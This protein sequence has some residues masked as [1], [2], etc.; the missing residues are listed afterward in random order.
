MAT[1]LL[2]L[3]SAAVLS[4][5]FRRRSLDR[6]ACNQGAIYF[7]YLRAKHRHLKSRSFLRK[8]FFKQG[9]DW[10]HE[11]CE[12]KHLA[13]GVGAVI[14]EFSN[15]DN[16][17]ISEVNQQSLFYYLE[18]PNLSDDKNLLCVT[19]ER[20]SPSNDS[21]FAPVRSRITW[22]PFLFNL[23]QFLPRNLFPANSS[24]F[25]LF[26]AE[27]QQKRLVL[28]RFYRQRERFI[29]EGESLRIYIHLFTLAGYKN[30]IKMI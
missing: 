13:A 3:I 14:K 4:S 9:L 29:M 16:E 23:S 12:T 2:T 1:V 25:T 15:W 30:Y 28:C 6:A 18:S 24:S 26:F 19:L 20:G 11:L 8:T 22:E 10:F 21:I 7:L 5:K 27:F 17:V